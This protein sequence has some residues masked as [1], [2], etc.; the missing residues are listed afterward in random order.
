MIADNDHLIIDD[1][2]VESPNNDLI[3]QPEPEHPD[4]RSL[5]DVDYQADS[6][7]ELDIENELGMLS[8]RDYAPV[9]SD[10][11]DAGEYTSR[12]LDIDESH[13]L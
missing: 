10:L 5:E 13:Q 6:Q 3:E 2:V 7:R 4:E 1:V 8:N 9:E 11:I 12:V